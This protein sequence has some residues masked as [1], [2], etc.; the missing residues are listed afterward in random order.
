[1]YYGSVFEIK[2]LLALLVSVGPESEGKDFVA[3]QGRVMRAT[4]S[5]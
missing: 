1:M 5:E 2:S 4:S 3:R